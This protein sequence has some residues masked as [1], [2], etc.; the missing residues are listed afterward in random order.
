MSTNLHGLQ[1]GLEKIRSSSLSLREQGSSFERL[2]LDFLSQDKTYAPQFEKVQTYGEWA[3]ARGMDERDTG[4][5]LVASNKDDAFF[6]AIQCKLRGD[7]STLAKR[8]IDSFIAASDT[9]DFNRR[10]LADTAQGG[11]T[12]AVEAQMRHS[13]SAFTRVGIAELG[14]SSIDWWKYFAPHGVVRQQKKKTSRPDQKIALRDVVRGLETADRG[15]L[16]MACGTGKTFVSLKVAERLAGKGKS[17]LFLVPSLSLMSQAVREWTVESG[18]ELHTFAVC[19][20]THVGKCLVRNEDTADIALHDLAYPA[21]T[22]AKKLAEKHRLGPQGKM[23]VV[24]ATYHSIDVI[25]TAQRKHGFPEF[26]LIICDE[27]HRTTGATMDSERESPFVKVHDQAR[28]QG[29]KRLYMTATP[30]VYVTRVKAAAKQKNAVLYSMDDEEKFGKE[31]H[32]LNFGDAVRQD[33]LSDYKVL[34]LALDEDRIARDIQKKLS[35]SESLQL[36]DATKILGCYKALAKQGISD[37]EGEEPMR[38]A[39]AFC[40]DIKSSELFKDNF[41]AVVDEYLSHQADPAPLRCKV[42]HVDGTMNTAIRGAELDWL[43]GATDGENA[44]HILSNARCLSEGVDVP[45]LDA[46][47]FVHARKSKVDIVQAVGRVMRKAQGKKLGYVVLP[48]V[49]PAGVAPHEALSSNKNYSIVWDVLNALRSHDEELNAD[50]NKAEFG[51][52]LKKIEIISEIEAVPEN[53]PGK[54]V[55]IGGKERPIPIPMPMRNADLDLDYDSVQQAILAKIVEKCGTRDYWENWAEDVAGIAEKHIARINGIISDGDSEACRAV[56]G[57][58]TSVRDTIN[59][60]VTQEEI[61][62]MLAQHIITKP[63]FDALFAGGN[64]TESNSVSQAMQAVLEVLDRHRVAKE[65]EDLS[66]FY[67]SVKLRVLGVDTADGRQKIIK[68]LYERFFKV[69]FPKMAERLG[70]VYTPIECVDF[71]IRSANDILQR[72]FGKSLGDEGIHIIEPFA[73]TGTFITRLMQIGVI[74]KEQL[75]HKY[76][77][78]L[79]ANELLLLA[80]YIAA[81]N[82]EM[83]YHDLVSDGG[84]TP[85]YQP[86]EGICLTDTFQLDEGGGDL[87]DSQLKDNNERRQRQKNLKNIRVIIGNPP[88]SS[89]QRSAND[90]NPNLKYSKLD[91]RIQADYIQPS[92]TT[93]NKISLYDSYIRAI[94]WAS[95]RIKD[96]GVIGFVTNAGWIESNASDGM[97]KCLQEEFS[98]IYI[99]HLRGNQRTSGERSRREGGKIFGQGSRAPIAIS[100]LVKNPEA[101]T[102]GNIHCHDIGDYLSRTEKLQIIDDFGSVDAITAQGKWRAI[103]PNEYH[104]WLGQRD[105]SF[106]Q[107]MAM[108]EKN[109]KTAVIF[110]NYSL[111]L[112]TSRDAWVYNPSKKALVGNVQRMI[113]FYNSERE[114]YRQAGAGGGQ[115]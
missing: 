49:V 59:S 23:T 44:C 7:A 41:T 46:V 17:V 55:D 97:R 88:Y 111:G 72:E 13:R 40:R 37:T 16:I 94:R 48:I 62:E 102:R 58:L 90:N 100:L 69:A 71:I 11:M 12:D 8:E 57:F 83:T 74:S 19:S 47:L 99:F 95:G 104:D 70:I 75:A 64:F 51:Q 93:G 96:A 29:R 42:R 38:R 61:V 30:R 84:S 43:R 82:I 101:K 107:H 108:G 15:R 87:L 80:Y 78:E 20:D 18:L 10:L 50:I 24:F 113:G 31:L 98:D 21:T 65:A 103:R 91:S 110:S 67:D 89:R 5:D 39:V 68:E 105:D 115:T 54:R 9:K 22:D 112:Q 1:A 79:H 4:I 26:D 73:G 6:T 114:R 27:A 53:P 56:D 76:H 36:D 28:V 25:S 14:N 66:R 77:H 32:L 63:V 52:R 92:L 86:F 34:V 85:R 109:A 45:S 35:S 60:A 2:V 81:I 106:Y 3:R 33:L